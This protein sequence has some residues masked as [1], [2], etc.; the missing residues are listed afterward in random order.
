MKTFSISHTRWESINFY[1]KPWR[2]RETRTAKLFN[3]LKHPLRPNTP[4]FFS[5][6]KNFH[7]NQMV[8]SLNNRWF[9]LSTQDIPILMKTK[10]QVH[11]MMFGVVTRD[12]EVMLPFIFSHSQRTD[13]E[14]YIMCQEEVVLNLEGVLL[15]DPLSGNRTMHHDTK[16]REPSL[17]CQEI[18]VT[19]SLKYI[20]TLLS[21]LLCVRRSWVKGQ[22][23]AM[24]HQRWTES[25]NNK[26]V[27]THGDHQEGLPYT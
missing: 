7:L 19:T 3:Q 5:Y 23:N 12:R 20:A 24:Q 4:C 27:F 22:Q 14:A 25:K 10:H 6:E 11:I 21:S 13:M 16:V 15:E 8:N 2:R 26:N 1:H 18:S 17:G 9:A